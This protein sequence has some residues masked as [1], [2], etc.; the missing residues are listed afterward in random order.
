MGAFGKGREGAMGQ[1]NAMAAALGF[2]AAIPLAAMAAEPGSPTDAAQDW[3]IHGQATLTWQAHPAF[4]SPYR[5]SNSLNPSA[6]GR[7]TFDATLY[8]GVRPWAAGEVWI[9]PE[10]DQGF[11]PV[12]PPTTATGGRCRCSAHA[13]TGSSDGPR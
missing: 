10:I 11:G 8:A 4:R 9:N 1:Q 13:C 7:E 5:G 2:W 3:A 6:N 12:T